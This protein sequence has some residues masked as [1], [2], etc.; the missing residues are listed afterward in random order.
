MIFA[1]SKL[2]VFRGPGLAKLPFRFYSE[3]QNQYFFSYLHKLSILQCALTRLE[4]VVEVDA[5]QTALANAATWSNP[6]SFTALFQTV[7]KNNS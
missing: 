3:F 2:K 1:G 5:E 4:V 7:S 6:N